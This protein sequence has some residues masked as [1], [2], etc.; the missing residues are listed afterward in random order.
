MKSVT[1]AVL[2]IA[3]VSAAPLERRDSTACS[4]A[5]YTINE[6]KCKNKCEYWDFKTDYD[7]AWYTGSIT[8]TND[9]GDDVFSLDT[10]SWE[11]DPEWDLDDD[12]DSGTAQ[13]GTPQPSITLTINYEEDE[14]SDDDNTVWSDYTD[15]S[16]KAPSD[17]DVGD[18]DITDTISTGYWE[19]D[20]DFWKQW[21]VKC[22]IEYTMSC[23]E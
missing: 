21:S 14:N 10:D 1:L 12:L 6:I 5:Y 16:M 17:I 13:S 11:K 22:E 19:Y 9:D 7:K 3:A 8:I 23:A 4:K 15:W 2:S 20:S 18:Y